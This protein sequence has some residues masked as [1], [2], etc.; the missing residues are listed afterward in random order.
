M[1][2][3]PPAPPAASPL[4]ADPPPLA[5]AEP[6]TAPDLR[7]LTDYLAATA[8]A[9][10]TPGGGSVV[11]VVGALG[12]ALG[13]MVA[14]LSAG[15]SPASADAGD[16]TG[17]GLD[18]VL[19]QLDALRQRLLSL[20]AADEAAYQGYRAAAALPKSTPPERAARAAA[21]QASLLA[22]TDVPLATAS[23]AA[24]L[25]ALLD[26]VARLGNRHALAD[27]QIAAWA[28]DL[29]VKG[30]LLNVRGNAALLKDVT[31]A[32]RYRAAADQIE[33]RAA[34]AVTDALAAARARTSAV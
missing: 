1:S 25:A 9:D 10:P 18:P 19:P 24:D 30:A 13:A 7:S 17:P 27:A 8:S 5:P 20:A 22:A 14:R 16:A 29:A 12:A 2:D 32:E 31:A 21:L 33:S 26:P 34:A 6:G 11:A 15:R 23:A 4:A 3:L 28:A